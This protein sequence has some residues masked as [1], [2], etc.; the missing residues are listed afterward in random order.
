MKGID[1]RSDQSE[2]RTR[3]GEQNWGQQSK[4]IQ[5]PAPYHCHN[6]DHHIY[7]VSFSSFFLVL[8]FTSSIQTKQIHHCEKKI[9]QL[10]S[11]LSFI[12]LVHYEL[13]DVLDALARVTISLKHKS[14][15]ENVENQYRH[16]WADYAW[17]S[18]RSEPNSY[19]Y[20][21]TLSCF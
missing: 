19:H 16:V 12:A 13:F 21:A 3:R 18:I 17:T 5:Y 20:S 14:T 7:T 1:T 8:L 4:T 15:L 2:A 11:G 10:C 6:N 9:K